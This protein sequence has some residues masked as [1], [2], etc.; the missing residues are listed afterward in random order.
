MKPEFHYRVQN[1]Q[2][3]LLREI[4]GARYNFVCSYL[5]E[6]LIDASKEVGLEIGN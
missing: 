6:A 4:G 1:P 5:R 3:S 2:V